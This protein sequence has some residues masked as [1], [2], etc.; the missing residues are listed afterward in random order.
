MAEEGVGPFAVPGADRRAAGAGPHGCDA[1]LQH[2]LLQLEARTG[3][4]VGS[5]VAVD[6]ERLT[7]AEAELALGIGAGE[8]PRQTPAATRRRAR[9]RSVCG[10]SRDDE[11]GKE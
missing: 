1:V 7:E 8:A 3:G 5:A 6:V 9:R 10:R 11:R 2:L 4:D